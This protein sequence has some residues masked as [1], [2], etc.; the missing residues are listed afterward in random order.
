MPSL[1]KLCLLTLAAGGHTFTLKALPSTKLKTLVLIG[2]GINV[3]ILQKIM[4]G[5]KLIIFAYRPG[6]A[7]ADKIAGSDIPLSRLLASLTDS[8][9]SLKDLVLFH[10]GPKLES[11]SLKIFENLKCLEVPYF[12]VLDIPDAE[13]DPETIYDRLRGQLPVSLSHIVLR[14]LPFDTRTKTIIEQ[15]AVLKTQNI[16]PNL[17]KATFNFF[18]AVASPNATVFNFGA[19]WGSLPGFEQKVREDFGKLYE[20]AGI[21]MVATLTDE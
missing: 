20:D 6:L 11:V 2:C 13:D 4:L 21:C 1:L 7:Q 18:N 16:L 12:G 5:Q 8:K 9:L 14:Y 19:I 15:L 10:P 17:D 3:R